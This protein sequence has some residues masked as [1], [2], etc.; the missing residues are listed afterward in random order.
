MNIE[1]KDSQGKVLTVTTQV[2]GRRFDATACSPHADGFTM[3]NAI[4]N[5]RIPQVQLEMACRQSIACNEVCVL[6]RAVNLDTCVMIVPNAGVLDDTGRQRADALMTDL[7]M[8]TQS[9]QVRAASLLVTHFAYVN[10]YPQEHLFGIL[11]AIVKL[12]RQSFQRLD[13]LGFQ[14]ADG[15]KTG[16]ERDLTEALNAL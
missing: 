8:A 6:P 4:V 13:M 12:R 3:L 5:H 9:P 7:F 1:F 16:F 10:R 14:V 11:D 2:S 15:I